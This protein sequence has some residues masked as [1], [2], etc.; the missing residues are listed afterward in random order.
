MEGEWVELIPRHDPS[1]RVDVESA[2]SADRT[3]LRAWTPNGT[4]AQ[5]FKLHYRA[6]DGAVSFEPACAP[7]TKIDMTGKH[8]QATTLWSSHGDDAPHSV[9]S[10][11]AWFP[12]RALASGRTTSNGSSRAATLVS[13]PVAARKPRL[14]AG[15]RTPAVTTTSSSSGP[16]RSC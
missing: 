8:N 11:S 13:L 1:L 3:A 14:F 5:K 4:D 15:P 9:I 6:A 16:P 7:G 12:S 2:G 10:S